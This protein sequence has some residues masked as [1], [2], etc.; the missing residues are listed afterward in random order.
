MTVPTYISECAPA[1]LRGRLV[2]INN[3]FI[4]GGQFIASILDGAFSYDKTNG[5]RFV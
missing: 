2:T 4:T 3:L 1:E 5:W